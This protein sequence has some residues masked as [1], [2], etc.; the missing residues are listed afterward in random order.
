MIRERERERQRERQRETE[1]QREWLKVKKFADFK[2]ELQALENILSITVLNLAV[3]RAGD[4]M[5]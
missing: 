2:G 4:V 1:R 5:M 3:M